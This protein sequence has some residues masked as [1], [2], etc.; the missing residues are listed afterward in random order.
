MFDQYPYIQHQPMPNQFQTVQR[1]N[2]DPMVRCWFVGDKKEFDM[3]RAEWNTIYIGI[4]RASKEIYTKQMTH[5]GTIDFFTYNQQTQE[6]LSENTDIKVILEKLKK[7]ELKLG[8][9]DEHNATTNNATNDD[10]AIQQHTAN[11]NVQSN[12]GW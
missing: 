10:G 12:D 11:A 9:K 6:T 8:E 2:Q 4:N 7:I 5:N 1:F 3:I